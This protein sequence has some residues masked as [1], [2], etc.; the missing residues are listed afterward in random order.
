[1][2]NVDQ[3][4]TDW[5]NFNDVC[6]FYLVLK[7]NTLDLRQDGNLTFYTCTCKCH[8]DNR[9]ETCLPF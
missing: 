5:F 2:E 8:N 4:H 3:L 9:L 7:G 6:Y 1:M